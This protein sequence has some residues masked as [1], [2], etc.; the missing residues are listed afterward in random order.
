MLANRLDLDITHSYGPS[1]KF[2]TLE[3]DGLWKCAACPLKFDLPQPWEGLWG[4]MSPEV[5]EARD[6]FIHDHGTEQDRR[7]IL[8]ESPKSEFV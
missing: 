6:H 3:D 8:G 5:R 7:I 1:I 4:E 2:L